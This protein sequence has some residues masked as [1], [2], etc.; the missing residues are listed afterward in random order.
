MKPRKQPK[1]APAPAARTLAQVVMNH[2]GVMKAAWA[3]PDDMDPLRREARLIQGERRYDPL[4]M[5][6]RQTPDRWTVAMVVAG[7]RYRRDYEVGVLGASS[8]G[9]RG[10]TEPPCPHVKA[11]AKSKARTRY[12]AA[13]DALGLTLH[14]FVSD[15]LVQR[16]SLV[17]ITKKRG[18]PR[19]RTAAMV[20]AAMLR[21]V[22]HYDGTKP[23][24]TKTP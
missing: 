3:D 2:P 12:D 19:D 9:G 5:L 11:L 8:A 1:P 6:H 23:A 16:Y 22:D 24:G 17:D 13:V 21:L 18:L 10:A 7:E 14:A 4:L 20:E 15:F